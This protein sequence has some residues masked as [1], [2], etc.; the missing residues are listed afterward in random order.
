MKIVCNF[1]LVLFF[2]CPQFLIKISAQNGIRS[3][4][5]HGMRLGEDKDIFKI[6]SAYKDGNR[7]IVNF[8]SP[9]NPTSIRESNVLING[10]QIS[11]LNGSI[12]FDRSGRSMVISFSSQVSSGTLTINGAKNFNQI[13]LSNNS[14]KI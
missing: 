9:V 10:R 2:F 6:V 4:S 13:S 3:H 5:Y 7:I 14:I 1:L 11:S 8:S 12:K